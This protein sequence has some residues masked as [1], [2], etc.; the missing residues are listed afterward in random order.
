VFSGTLDGHVADGTLL[1]LSEVTSVD[2]FGT[3]PQ[4]FRR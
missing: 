1:M 4:I 3:K 2:P